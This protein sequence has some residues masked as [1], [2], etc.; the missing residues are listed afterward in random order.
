MNLIDVIPI[1]E[2]YKKTRQELMNNMNITDV[3]EFRRKLSKLREQ[4]IIISDGSGYY[5]PS[6]KEEYLEFIEKQVRQIGDT[7]KTIEL[8]CKEMEGLEDV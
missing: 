8:A 5:L 2:K 4:Y 6:S 1:G 7:T 3:R